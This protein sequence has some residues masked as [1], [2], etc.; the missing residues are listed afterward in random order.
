LSKKE[1]EELL[2][3]TDKAELIDK[4][5]SKRRHKWFL[6]SVA[7]IDFDDVCQ[8]IRAHIHKKWHQWD[9]ERALEP[10]LNKIISN[11]LKNILRNNYGNYVR[12]CLN[13]PFNQSGPPDGERE[14]LC[15]FTDSGMQCNECPLYAKWESTK[16][17]AYNTKMAV[18]MENH[19]HEMSMMPEQAFD[20]LDD[21]IQRVHLKME[22]VLPEKKFK[23]YKMLYMDNLSEEDVAKEMGYKTSETG[24]TAG[25]KQI[26]NLKKF[27]KKTVEELM[28]K[29]DIIITGGTIPY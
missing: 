15:A 26:R 5:L 24:R 14:G 19:A 2:T 27:F 29:H 21:S 22:E 28:E 11:Q 23:I 3:Y 20:S 9:Q 7:W 8:I 25:Y 17:D 18:T 12:P 10:W 1:K 13:C 16:K 6:Y 4:E